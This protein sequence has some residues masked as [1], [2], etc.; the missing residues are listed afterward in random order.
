MLSCRWVVASVMVALALIVPAS[1]QADYS[2]T[3]R[4]GPFT[5]PG[6]S[7]DMPGMKQ[8]I[9][10]AV[11]K[12]CG[13]CYITSFTPD[14]VDTNYNHVDMMSD[15]LMLHHAVFA[16]QWRS[17]ATC[18]GSWLGLAGERFFASGDERSRVAFTTADGHAYGY[19][20]H[21]YDQWNLLVDLMNMKPGDKQ[22][23]VSVTFTYRSGWDNVRP[24]KPVW[25]DIDN[26]GDSEFSVPAGPY[27]RDRYWQ[28][29]WAGKV[30]GMVGHLHHTGQW[31]ESTD[32]NSGTLICHS[33]PTE[34]MEHVVS[35]SPCT[36]LPVTIASGDTIRLVAAY[37]SDVPRDDVMGIMLGYVWRTG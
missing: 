11:S 32:V 2:K 29:P 14:L 26:C 3:V 31:I 33:E 4:Y 25:L 36:G 19:R 12:P 1:A 16:S 34:E 8:S 13:E 7:A 28:S 23:Y 20:L 30:V 21:W 27:Q 37:N 15:G 9:R 18:S 6:G 22:V 17:D 10:L 24:V 35:M 5:V